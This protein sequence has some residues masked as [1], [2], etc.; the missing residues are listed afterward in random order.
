[1]RAT[2]RCKFLRIT[3]KNNGLLAASLIM[4]LVLVGGE[5]LAKGNK[6]PS[7]GKIVLQVQTQSGDFQKWGSSLAFRP[8]KGRRLVFRWY[9]NQKDVTKVSWSLVRRRANGSYTKG[10][11]GSAGP[12]RK[13]K[14]SGQWLPRKN[15]SAYRRFWIDFPDYASGTYRVFL[16]GW[17]L[18]KPKIL[19]NPITLRVLG[20]PGPS[21]VFNIPTRVRV[22]IK[23]IFVNNDSDAGPRGAG[24]IKICIWLQSGPHNAAYARWA[25]VANTGETIKLN[26]TFSMSG[27]RPDI[28]VR[29]NAV[30]D[31]SPSGLENVARYF[32]KTPGVPLQLGAKVRRRGIN[33]NNHQF[34]YATKKRVDYAQGKK[35]IDLPTAYWTHGKGKTPFSFTTTS[36]K[37][38]RLTVTG[39]F[40]VTK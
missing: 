35:I 12:I 2:T 31:D 30:E 14:F 40:E 21:T 7:S 20:K 19:S 23:T 32:I 36:T 24:E 29:L 3:L 1:M 4:S 6:W 34:S 27:R 22:T 11:Y 8:M 18:H 37:P 15:R 33:C 26:H 39:T 38:L 5:A 9:T 13:W 25:Y 16:K 10:I 17:V 28:I